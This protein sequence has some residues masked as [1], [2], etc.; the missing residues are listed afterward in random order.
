MKPKVPKVVIYHSM[1][2]DQ[3]IY[4]LVQ[5]RVD[6]PDSD[7]ISVFDSAEDAIEWA[8]SKPHPSMRLI[9]LNCIKRACHI[10][11][12]ELWDETIKLPKNE[13]FDSAG[14]RECVALHKVTSRISENIKFLWFENDKEWK[15]V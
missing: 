13:R 14:H 3:Y 5:W 10:R 15:N 7:N 11:F 2:F 1:K 6:I 12:D 8:K 4:E 9:Y